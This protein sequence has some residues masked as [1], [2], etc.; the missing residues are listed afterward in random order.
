MLSARPSNWDSYGGNRLAKNSVVAALT[1]L[2]Q[3]SYA[4]QSKPSISLTSEGGLL[5][6]WEA[7]QASVELVFNPQE[8]PW[9]YYCDNNTGAEWEG[10]LHE[11]ELIEK[12]LW[13]ASSA[14]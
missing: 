7:V 12:W 5:F 3:F 13:Q 8:L 1:F 14:D 11:G 9:V 10:F 2:S 6:G 4:I